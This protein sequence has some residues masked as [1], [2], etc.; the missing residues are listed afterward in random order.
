MIARG[1]REAGFTIVEVLVAVLI[2]SIASMTTFTL[3]SAATRNAQRAEAS[4]VALEYAEQELELLRSMEDKN[5]AL[6][7]SPSTST[8]PNSPNSRVNNGTFALSRQPLGNYRNLVVNGGSLYGG[9]HVTGGTVNPGPTKFTSGDVSG[10][11]YR[12]IVWRNDEKCSEASCPGKQDYKQIV[13]AVRLDTPPNQAAE[14]GYVEVQSNFVS[15]TDNKENDPLAGANGKVVTAQQFFLTD[16]ACSASGSTSRQEP[17]ANHLLHN[18]LGTCASGPHTGTTKGAPDALLLG[19]PPDPDPAD[20]NNPLKYDYANDSYLDTSPDAGVGVQIRKDDTNG[21]HYTPTGTTNPESQVHRWVTDPM[22]ESFVL[23]GKV[24]LEVFTQSINKAQSSGKLCIYLFKRHE[25][26]SPPVATDT[27]L[28]DSLGGTPYWTYFESP[29][30][31]TELKAKILTMTLGG[32]PHTIPAGDR[33]GVAFSV[34]RQSTPA[35]ALSFM[36]DHPQAPTRIEVDTS[37]PI[38]GG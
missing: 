22:A 15:P 32:A 30:W 7:T 23:E 33:L 35:D 27:M 4:Q 34:E 14:R 16:T 10:R 12:Y 18:T 3:M 37:T 13:V 9:G 8:N 11:V 36:Y 26:G 25:V 20:I 24:T 1:D 6:T 31:T 29:I 38:D 17:T 2:V 19:S 21:C 5:L 28:T